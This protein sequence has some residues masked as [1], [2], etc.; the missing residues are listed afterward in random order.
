MS[1]Q[2][3]FMGG[4]GTDEEYIEHRCGYQEE[5][6]RVCQGLNVHSSLGGNA[7]KVRPKSRV[8]FPVLP[9]FEL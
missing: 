1:R 6:G 9:Q 4:L 2:V 7:M 3:I 5:K 8:R